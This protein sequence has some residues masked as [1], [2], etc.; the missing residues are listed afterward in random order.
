MARRP[1]PASELDLV[2]I[3]NLVTILIP[4]LLFSAQFV[5]LATIDSSLPAISEAQTLPPHTDP[6]PLNL[7]IAIDA[8]G[9]TVSADQALPTDALSIA[10]TGAAMAPG[11]F[12]AD[13]LTEVLSEIKEA[14]PDEDLVMLS[15]TTEIPYEILIHT[16][17]AA[18]G[19]TIG[20]E[21]FPSV[22]L[23]GGEA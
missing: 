13:R 6:P 14:W 21:L 11:S 4:F 17:D 10:T 1:A 20:S 9:Y 3:M 18:S 16:M 5:S 7:R 22:V 19:R 15:P 2:P 8:S 12:D 23:T